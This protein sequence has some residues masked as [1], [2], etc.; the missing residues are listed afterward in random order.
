MT[1]LMVKTIQQIPT[2][3]VIAVSR[4]EFDSHNLLQVVSQAHSLERW[5]EVNLIGPSL[6]T[7]G[8]ISDLIPSS[9]VLHHS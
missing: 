3:T 1:W 4:R 6:R 7:I 8:V 5:S 9:D 2:I